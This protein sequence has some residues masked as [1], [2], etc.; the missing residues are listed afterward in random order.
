MTSLWKNLALLLLFLNA[1]PLLCPRLLAHAGPT[2][3][4]VTRHRILFVTALGADDD[5]DYENPETPIS[6]P[7]VASPPIIFQE[8]T[9][10]K[11]NPCD[12]N[13]ERCAKISEKTGCLCPGLS[14][15]DVPPHAP[16]ITEIAPVSKGADIGK[17]EV[18][19]CAPS[20]A[21]SGYR[22][23]I[24][25]NGDNSLEFGE[26]LRKGV[27]GSLEVGTKVCVE[28][29]NSAGHSAPS[30]FSCLRYDAPEP[31]DNSML[32]GVIGGGLTLL[33]LIAIAAVILWKCKIC[34]NTK[35]DS[36]DGLG[37]P[38][39]NTEGTL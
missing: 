14:G 25:R 28:A 15:S 23:V 19:W 6:P 5:E 16:R 36:D 18:K 32:A 3:P 33:L 37:N 13:Q 27:V 2:S 34:R 22:V 4:P 35:R 12:E 30:E 31:S 24:E 9:L 20:S 21:V 17:V 7:I 8:A 38:S 29:V 11:Y 1:S 10:C 39:Y 26:T